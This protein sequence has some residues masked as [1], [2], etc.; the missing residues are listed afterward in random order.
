MP[1]PEAQPHSPRGRRI[2]GQ[3]SRPTMVW[4]HECSWTRNGGLLARARTLFSIMVHSTSSSWMMMSFFRIL[5]AYS[6]SVPCGD[7]HTRYRN[8]RDVRLSVAKRT[9]EGKETK[10]ERKQAQGDSRRTL[11]RALNHDTLRR[12]GGGGRGG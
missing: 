8:T 4:K 5:M 10:D 3:D 11:A 7:T 1:S 2:R 6:S 12:K 9:E